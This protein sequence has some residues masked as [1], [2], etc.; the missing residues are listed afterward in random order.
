MVL[1]K[2]LAINENTRRKLGDNAREWARDVLSFD[3]VAETYVK[4]STEVSA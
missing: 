1:T 4:L 2:H 3:T